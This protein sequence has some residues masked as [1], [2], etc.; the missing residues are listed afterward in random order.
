MRILFTSPVLE[1][2]AAGGPQLRIEN[3]IK[4]LSRLCEMSI[5]SRSPMALTGGDDALVFYRGYCR[6]IE[7][8][9]ATRRM[10]ANR[11][12]RKLQR[13]AD[14][15]TGSAVHADARFILDHVR[16]HDIRCIWFGYGNISFP[17][18]KQI[19]S[20]RPR[21]KMVCDTDSVWSRFILRELPYATGLRRKQIEW[22]GRK[23]Q[24][25]ERDWVR[26]CDVTTAVSEVDAQYYRAIALDPSRVRVFSNVI[27]VATYEV[28]PSPPP[29]F[30]K[31]CMY[32]AGTFGHYHSPM[33]TAAR[34]VLDEVLPRVRRRIPDVHFY[35]VGTGSDRMLGHRRGSHV[36]VTGKLPSVLPHLCS[37]DVALV[38]LKFESGTRF[39]ILEAGV[40]GVP[41]VST[42]LGA[43]G[44][45]V[46]SGKDILLA[47][48][49][50]N[51]AAAIVKL[52]EDRTFAAMI[53]ENCRTLVRERYSIEAL[54][55]EAR[56][57]LESL[58]T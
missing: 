53:A 43:E 47:D 13:I 48:E 56:G 44:I 49:P 9:P 54:M 36:T 4:A 33:D 50:D 26:S 28:P 34:W 14:S 5:I 22:A 2:P 1:H 15:I 37:A 45:P 19:Q 6:S 12:V 55:S 52:I 30:R 42:T 35:I 16:Q 51:F 41:V 27:D 31:P 46:T 23:K 21:L 24:A 57:I 7:V 17:L 29:N 20:M 32:L 58:A 39:K 10:S 11:Y 18:I 40:C 25:E 8:T 3:S 38:P